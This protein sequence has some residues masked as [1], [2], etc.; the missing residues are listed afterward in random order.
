M[1]SP[2]RHYVGEW[3]NVWHVTYGIVVVGTKSGF[4]VQPIV[5]APLYAM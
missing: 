2:S 4:D 3:Y 1:L 5:L